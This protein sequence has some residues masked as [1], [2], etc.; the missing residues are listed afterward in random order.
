MPKREA[1]YAAAMLQRMTLLQYDFESRCF[2]APVRA[3]PPEPYCRAACLCAGRRGR[4]DGGL[5]VFEDVPSAVAVVL[6]IAAGQQHPGVACA[7]LAACRTG[8]HHGQPV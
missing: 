2:T 1:I 7:A 5:I 6:C 8:N 3:P 4:V